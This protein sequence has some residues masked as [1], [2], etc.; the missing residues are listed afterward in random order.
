MFSKAKCVCNQLKPSLYVWLVP[1]QPDQNDGSGI[2]Q[3][4]RNVRKNLQIHWNL[5]GF[6]RNKMKPKLSGLAVRFPYLFGFFLLFQT[7]FN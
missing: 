7:L 4:A 3:K 1:Y 6:K 2:E 5:W